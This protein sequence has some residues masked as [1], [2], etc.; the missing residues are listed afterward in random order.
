MSNKQWQLSNRPEGAVSYDNFQ[1]AETEIPAPEDGEILVRTLYLSVAPVMRM[2]MT[3]GAAGIP[4]LDIG[5]CMPGR[6][7]GYVMKSNHPEYGIG[8]VVH[9]SI[10]WQEYA[11]LK[12]TAETLIFKHNHHDIPVSTAIGCMGMTG[13][14]AYFGLMD[15]GELKPGQ[16]VVISAAA[17]GVGCNVGQIAKALGC[18]TIGIA[19]GPEKCQMIVDRCGCDEAVDYKAGDVEG[20]LRNLLGDAGAN[21][22]FDNVGGQC[23][24]P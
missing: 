24:T 18:R 10:G 22:V 2:Y 1:L 23:S 5:D 3:T 13:Y 14:T 21:V 6:G 20:Q 8:D 4:K 19:G 16:T 9:G 7:V 15:V 17:G 12:P 11:L